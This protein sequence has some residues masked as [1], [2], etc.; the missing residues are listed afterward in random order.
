MTEIIN[1][2]KSA[3]VQLRCQLLLL[4]LLLFDYCI[5]H[6]PFQIDILIKYACNVASHKIR[7]RYI[8]QIYYNIYHYI[9]YHMY[10]TQLKLAELSGHG[11]EHENVSCMHA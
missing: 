2:E 5:A 1:L 3:F 9:I 11:H 4:L 7:I 8:D 10:D 6:M